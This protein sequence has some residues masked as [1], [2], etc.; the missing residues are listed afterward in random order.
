MGALARWV[1]L[2]WGWRR[3]S[4]A[5]VAGAASATAVAPF[6]L[7]AV[8]FVTFPILVWLIDGSA[9]SGAAA[10]RRRRRGAL[11]GAA[12]AGWFFGFG[13]FLLGLYWIGSAFLVE[14]DTFAWLMPFAIVL[15]PAG[16]ALFTAL[17]SALAALLWSASPWRVLGL[18]SALTFSEWLR[19]WI[20]TGFPWNVFGYALSGFDP[21]M[22]AASL[23]GV[24][25]LTFV[26]VAVFSAPAAM[27]ASDPADT[28]LR[29]LPAAAALGILVLVAGY[30]VWRLP[31]EPLAVQEDLRLRIV[32]P[33][34]AQANKWRPELRS[35]NFSRVLQLSDEAT[36]PDSSG[37]GDVDL[38]IWPETAVPFLVEEDDGVRAAIAALLP[39]GT[40]LITG[41]VRRQLGPRPDANEVYN[42]VLVLNDEAEIE[43]VY[44]KVRLVPFGEYLP[45]QDLLE[46]IGLRQ[47]TNLR[48]GFSAG[49][50]R[51]TVELD[52]LP[53]MSPLICYEIIF[54]GR[55][56]SRAAR[57][58]W[59]LNLT[60]DAWFG[61]SAGPR[62]H[63]R[64]ARMRAVEEGLAVARA[65][66][67]G[68]SAVIDPYGRIVSELQLN[69]EGVID[70]A[71]PKPLPPTVFVRYGPIILAFL[72]VFGALG[73]GAGRS[74]AVRRQRL[75]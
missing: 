66:N 14:A 75:A 5:F 63:L 72:M 49:E 25:G 45:F 36:S 67:T 9:G 44:D 42:S 46:R 39:P 35:E 7:F 4:I 73:A 17:G 22:Q 6:D 37:I 28:R 11:L 3:A 70:A 50:E 33:N 34:I 62:Q 26:A 10:G 69:S 15:L 68:I 30:G 8:L 13:Y 61:D 43:A 51:V 31:S 23:F 19:G 40:R 48:G 54:E 1:I 27:V 55:V 52:G 60:N 2:L 47:L 18:A 20:L 71:L 74:F 59:L 24:S 29:V 12:S 16:L 64:Q 21:L 58:D 41:S 57:P 56:A 38:L 32:Q 65:A 53:P